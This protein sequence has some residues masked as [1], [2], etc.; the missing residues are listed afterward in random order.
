MKNIM[1]IFDLDGTLTTRDTFID[2]I[3]FST[4]VTGFLARAVSV[5]PSVILYLMGIIPNYRAKEIVLSHF[6]K[7]WDEKKFMR[8]ASEYSI[9][10]LPKILNKKAI[11]RVDWHRS[12]GHRIVIVTASIG[13]YLKDWCLSQ[14]VDLIATEA[15]ARD[16]IITGVLATKNCYGYEK[17]R[18]IMEKYNLSGFSYIYAYGDSP[19]DKEMLNLANEKHYRDG[20]TAQRAP[21]HS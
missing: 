21:L 20:W 8:I 18:R 1:A 19:A 12:Q 11:A 4:G 14:G 5:S 16:G 13:A 3:I 2:F 17:V 6:F 15:E 9:K 10:R 7:G